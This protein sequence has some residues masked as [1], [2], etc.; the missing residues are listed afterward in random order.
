MTPTLASNPVAY[1]VADRLRTTAPWE[2]YGQLARR[3]T[4]CV[5]TDRRVEFLRGPLSSKSTDFGCFVPT[6]TSTG[7]GFMASTDTS[8]AGS[9]PPWPKPRRSR[10]TPRSRRAHRPTERSAGA[11][12]AEYSTRNSDSPVAR[13]EE[14]PRR[15]PSPL[16]NFE[17]RRPELRV[18]SGHA[19][20]ELDRELGRPAGTLRGHVH[21]PGDRGES[22]GGPEG[23]PP[24]EYWVGGSCGRSTPPGPGVDVP[25]RARGPRPGCPTGKAPLHGG[26]AGRLPAEGDLVDRSRRGRLPVLP[27][28]TAREIA[29]A[30]GSVV[31]SP[32]VTIGRR[33]VPVG[34]DSAPWDDEGN[35]TGSHP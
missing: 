29:P 2:V 13:L 11:P 14:V 19:L 30:A 17:G 3:G 35:A 16:R 18:S 24:G 28:V 15:P 33:T 1:R 9:P 12:A 21:G 32:S 4:N 34:T 22:I 10:D 27:G 8:D 31:A 6:K 25:L 23:A 5:S 7:T 20:R 26:P